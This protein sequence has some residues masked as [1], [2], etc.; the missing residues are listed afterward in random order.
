MTA[1]II[2][3]ILSVVLLFGVS[4]FLSA[5]IKKRTQPQTGDTRSFGQMGDRGRREIPV[6][7]LSMLRLTA[8]GL[9][10]ILLLWALGGASMVWVPSNQFAT[11]KR[12]YFGSPLPPG[13]TVAL[14]GQLGPQARIITA[15][16]HFELFIALVYEIDDSNKVFTVPPGKCALM[17]AKDGLNANG[18]SSF[19]EPWADNVKMSMANDAVFFLTKGKGQRG[20][21][22]S[23]L[24]PAN[25]TINPFL[26]EMPRLIDATRIDQGTVGVVKSSVHAAVDFGPFKR[27]APTSMELTVLTAAKI[28]KGAVKALLVPVGAIGVWEEPLP[29]GL[30][31]I[32]TD[33]YKVTKA[34]AIVQINEYKGGY[35]RRD[36]EI[37]LDDEAKIKEKRSENVVQAVREAADGAIL[38]KPEGWDVFQELRVLTQISP[39]MAPY[40]VASLGI[41]DDDAAEVIEDRVITPIIRS[42]TRDVLGG[43]QISFVQ[44]KAKLNENGNPVLNENGE[45]QTYTAREFRAV[46]VLDLLENRTSLEAAI[47]E[48][49]RPEAEKEGITLL[50][51]RLAESAIPP[52]LL[53]ARKREQLAQQLTK[54][55]IQE[56]L[57][58]DQRQLTENARALASQQAE[59]VTAEIAMQAAEKNRTARKTQGEAE[60]E[61]FTAIAEGQRA[62]MSVFGQEATMRMQ[63][64]GQSLKLIEFLAEKKPEI[65]IQG[66]ASA[67]KFVP[68]IVVTNSGGGSGGTSPEGMAAI[69]ASVLNGSVPVSG[70]QAAKPVVVTTGK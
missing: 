11:L 21:Q 34:P 50:E 45:T 2:K 23:V 17:S 6:S 47:E 48:R 44:T 70:T 27:P 10:I 30:Y 54:A 39:E 46:R 3:L 35:T 64:F 51:V 53:V 59:L 33:A 5:L 20:Q 8:R 55:L 68:N 24:T 62:Q 52:E 4:R 63:M 37:W 65:L 57:A 25:Y 66:L 26:W 58:Q 31:F 15:G 38:T 28:P 42:V 67:N 56:K 9:G 36:V 22:A 12:V 16:F 43:T 29:N 61:Y 14:E 13:Q 1:F 32:N 40:V 18:G 60:K 49:A 41:K 69:F 7:V 19:A